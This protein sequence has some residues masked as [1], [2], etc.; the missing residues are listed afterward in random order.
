MIVVVA[1]VITSAPSAPVPPNF[2]T[3]VRNHAASLPLLLSAG[4]LPLSPDHELVVTNTEVSLVSTSRISV[5][6]P[7]GDQIDF[8]KPFLAFTFGVRY[9]AVVSATVFNTL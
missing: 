1:D 9:H 6:L 8:D 7:P 2:T 3:F 4:I 5:S